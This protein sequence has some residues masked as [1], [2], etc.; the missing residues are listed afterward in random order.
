MQQS[1]T[2]R[3]TL[4]AY[5]QH[6]QEYL[7]G[8]PHV[9]SDAFKEWI[10]RALALVPA[11]ST[12]L[13]FG[14]A[15][16][17]DADYMESRG[18]QVRRTDAAK[19]FVDLM[20]RQGHA[21][22]VLD[23]ITDELGGPYAMVFAN[24]VLLHFTPDETAHVIKKVYDSLQPG[25]VF[26]CSVKQGEGSAWSDEKLGAPRY[27]TYWSAEKLRPLLEQASFEVLELRAA[28]DVRRAQTTWL[29]VIACR[30]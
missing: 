18:Y 25:G 20:R 17:R 19:A 23:A 15:F 22:D 7:A 21:A 13:E 8:T 14:S 4:Q 9:S 24:A 16:G 27:F 12:I 11:G 1:D 26:A 3:Q 29:H 28:G 6:V 10:D 2:N 5:E 30:L